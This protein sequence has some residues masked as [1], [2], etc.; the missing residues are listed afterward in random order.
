MEWDQDAQR[1]FMAANF[2]KIKWLIPLFN[3][4]L[5]LANLNILYAHQKRSVD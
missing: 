1:I 5:I 4:G 3:S 2:N